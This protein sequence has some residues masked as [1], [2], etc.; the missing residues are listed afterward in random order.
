MDVLTP[1][2][3]RRCMTR[4]KA[5]N[6]KPEVLL[7]K[8]LFAL[9]FRYR[10]HDRR[11]PGTPD[12]VFPKF[13]AAV[14]VNGCF[15]HGH[16]CPL[17]AVPQ[18]NTDFWLQKIGATRARDKRAVSSLRRMGWRVLTV[19][20]CTLRR[21]TK[22]PVGAVATRAARWLSGTRGL[23]EIPRIPARY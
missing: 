4:I 17:F 1:E 7:R 10:L 19:W 9:G 12:L 13:R 15:W 22:V 8:A 20:E 2:Q 5:R 23:G 18:T 16:D 21:P 3:R 6:T 11:L 14:F